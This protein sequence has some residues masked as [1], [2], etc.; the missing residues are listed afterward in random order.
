MNSIGTQG[1]R[2]LLL[3]P[4]PQSFCVTLGESTYRSL[5]PFLIY[6]M[7]RHPGLTPEG[8]WEDKFMYLRKLLSVEH[9]GENLYRYRKGLWWKTCAIF[10][11]GEYTS[12]HKRHSSLFKRNILKVCSINLI[13]FWSVFITIMACVV[14]IQLQYMARTFILGL[15]WGWEYSRQYNS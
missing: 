7:G 4:P 9:D 2:V 6:N 5:P 10:S 13:Y 15:F 11:S 12:V 3:L 1:I 8:C 14:F